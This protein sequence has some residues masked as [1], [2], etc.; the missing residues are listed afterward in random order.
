MTKRHVLESS[1]DA[2]TSA[3]EEIVSLESILRT[4]EL[5]RRPSR[6]PDYQKENSA[7]VEL[8]QALADSPRTILQKLADI[9]LGVCQ[10]G[11][12]GISLLTKDDGAKRFY[13]PAIAGKW[14][15]HIGGGTPRDFGPCG[16]VLDRNST[17]LFGQVERRYRYFQP[18]VPKV[19]EALLVPFYVDDKA[20]GTLWAVAHDELRKFDAEDERI[21]RSL[22]K[23]ASSAYQ[24]LE[25]LDAL[26]FQIAEREKAEAG[27]RLAHEAAEEVLRNARGEL[28]IRVTE[29]TAALRHQITERE[30]AE[31]ELREISGRL[32]DLRDT[33]QRRI[34]R[35][36]HD[37]VGQLL[38]AVTMSL[39]NAAKHAQR[40][41]GA[42]DAIAQAETLVQETLKEVRIVA[43]LLHPPLLEETGLPSAIRWYLEGFSERGAIK[44]DF[45]VTQDFGRLPIE[46]ETAI[47][48][49]I[50]ECLTNVHRHS[51]SK[52]AK[53]RLLR[54]TDELRVEVEDEGTGIPR[55]HKPGVGLRGMKERVAQFGGTLEISSNDKGTT[56]TTRLPLA[57][58]GQTAN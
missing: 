17:L 19:E 29:R 25:S 6:P 40:N 10:A 21:M 38:T 52:T 45:S 43:H 5:D 39:A 4:E 3:G 23:F 42:V 32:L 44:T 1:S 12:A 8:A 58:E 26:K 24:I 49:V 50:Q 20:V 11:S 15:P 16:D 37:S 54:A 14:K 34:A 55:E 36:L 27:L 33:E 13:W 46:L 41:P 28:E 48:R 22:G 57:N 31:D 51:G 2:A 35:D 53:V 9:I 56:I 18:V 47:F 30:R 7:L